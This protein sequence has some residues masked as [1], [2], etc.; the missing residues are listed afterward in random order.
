MGQWL[1]DGVPYGDGDIPRQPA[2][3]GSLALTL[4]LFFLKR[5]MASGLASRLPWQKKPQIASM[6]YCE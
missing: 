6:K 3:K 1:F 4:T 2:Y 5:P